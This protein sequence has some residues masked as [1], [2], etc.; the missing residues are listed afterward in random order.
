V[1]ATE[2]TWPAKNSCCCAT[3][4]RKATGARFLLQPCPAWSTRSNWASSIPA[5]AAMLEALHRPLLAQGADTLV[6]GCTH[7]PTGDPALLEAAFARLLGL[8]VTA[9]AADCG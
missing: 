2:R 3:R 4:S 9:I 6:L 8:R 5:S 7:Y 1:L